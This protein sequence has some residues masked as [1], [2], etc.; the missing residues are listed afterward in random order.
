MTTCP[1]PKRKAFIRTYLELLGLPI[2][3]TVVDYM[4]PNLPPQILSLDVAKT[5]AMFY[6]NLADR[7]AEEVNALI[8]IID[9]GDNLD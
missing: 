6:K 5:Y 8:A 1:V 2:E 7:H 9:A 4:E 3:D